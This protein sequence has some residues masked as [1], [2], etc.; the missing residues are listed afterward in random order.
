MTEVNYF[1]V[2]AILQ[3][4]FVEIFYL[5]LHCLNNI[6]HD[7]FVSP[8]ALH[9]HIQMD[10]ILIAKIFTFHFEMFY[11]KKNDVSFEHDNCN[12]K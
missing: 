6:L 11:I 2:N 9:L 10:Y 12:V 1:M 7:P 3:S 8:P 4:N 5:L